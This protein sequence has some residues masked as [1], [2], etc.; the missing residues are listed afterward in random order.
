MA[1]NSSLPE[2]IRRAAALARGVQV[3]AQLALDE[4]D[5]LI[6]TA[7]A[8]KDGTTRRWQLEDL[9][10]YARLSTAQIHRIIYG[11]RGIQTGGRR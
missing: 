8:T 4:R 3:D 9:A 5:R 2:D 11:G 6:R 7:Y 10:S 1:E